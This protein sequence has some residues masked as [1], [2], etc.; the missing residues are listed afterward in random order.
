MTCVLL[1]VMYDL[2]VA[3]C[4][5][6]VL[7]HVEPDLFQLCY[8]VLM[9]MCGTHHQP[10]FALKILLEMKRNGVHPNAMTYGY[11]NKVTVLPGYTI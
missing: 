1:C 5:V 6:F 9:Q 10:A 3:M 2:C 11:Y 7:F 8:R 4:N